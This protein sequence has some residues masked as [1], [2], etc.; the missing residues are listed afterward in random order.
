M[1]TAHRPDRDDEPDPATRA[2]T[3]EFDAAPFEERPARISGR[4]TA[5]ALLA[6]L[7]LA[8]LVALPLT[9]GVPLWIRFET[10]LSLWWLVWVGVLTRVLYVA[11]RVDDDHELGR[12]HWWF[13]KRADD[14]DRAR[15]AQR[16]KT[17]RTLRPSSTAGVSIPAGVGATA[18]ALVRKKSS[19]RRTNDS[20]RFSW[21]DAL[22]PGLPIG[23]GFGVVLLAILGLAVLV[24]SIWLLVEVLIP[25]LAFAAYALL[26][27]MLTS[28]AR[29][30]DRCRGNAVAALGWALAFGTM[31]VAPLAGAVWL[32]H[33][34]RASRIG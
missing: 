30:G 25:T 20:D 3:D 4:A 26:R 6:C 28:A 21:I 23:E 7:A 31:Y 12:F 5:T 2:R 10:A 22:S 33:V 16:S 1:A 14:V 29:L 24:L 15:R 19:S 34:L 32:G 8:A 17:A 9:R 18:R 11:A 13:S 27:T